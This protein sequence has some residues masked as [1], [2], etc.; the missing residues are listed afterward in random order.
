MQVIK[1]SPNNDG[2]YSF[3]DEPI[4]ILTEQG[5]I[6][7]TTQLF[8]GK[9]QIGDTIHVCE[10]RFDTNKVLHIIFLR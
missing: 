10:W 4:T 6:N 1:I 2:S 5:D 9:V 8:Y 7:G 3:Y